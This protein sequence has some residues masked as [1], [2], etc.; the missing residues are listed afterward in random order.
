MPS[1][2]IPPLVPAYP[3]V[4]QVPQGSTA[5][6][7]NLVIIVHGLY[8][9]SLITGFTSIVGLIIA[10]MKRPEAA[11]TIYESHLTYAIRT[12]WIGL[13]AGGISFV[14]M[15]VLIGIPM[16]VAVGIWF[17]VRIVRALL[18]VLDDKPIAK[19]AGWF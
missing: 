18:A 1:D 13:I 19:P 3:A 7:K 12:F 8:A 10:Y 5:S 14:L 15:F 9:A 4:T 16:L 6:M 2:P 11:G 17:I